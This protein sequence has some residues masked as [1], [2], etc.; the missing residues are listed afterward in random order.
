M[1][2]EISETEDVEV[3]FDDLL[4]EAHALN[5]H[6]S[7]QAP[8]N[9]IACGDIGGAVIDDKVWFG[10]PAKRFWVRWRRDRQKDGD[11]MLT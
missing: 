9:Y 10:L 7:D 2:V 4:E 11:D 8:Q 6:E 1:P 3:S 5:I